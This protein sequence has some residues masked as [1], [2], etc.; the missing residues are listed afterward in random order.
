MTRNGI[1]M[2]LLGIDLGTSSVKV[3]VIDFDSGKLVTH[4]ALPKEE[5][6]IDTPRTGWAE[7]S[8]EKWWKY[9]VQAIQ[10][11][12]G[13]PSV[14]ALAIKGIGISYQMHGLVVVDK[15]HQPL[16]P[17]IIW[18]DSRAVEIGRNAFEVLG[19]EQCLEHFL[20]SPGNFTASKLKW[21][22]DNEPD[23]YKKIYKLMLPGDYLAMK[24]TGEIYTTISGLSE[25]ILWDFATK[26]PAKLL[27]DYYEIDEQL[28][29]TA[30]PSFGESGTLSKSAAQQLG[31]KAGIPIAY[32]AGDQPNNAFSL[33]AVHPG[34]IAATAGTS[35]V[36]YGVTDS[37]AYDRMS[38]VNSFAHVNYTEEHTS[39]GILLCVNGTGILNSWLKRNLSD[40][41]YEEMNQLALEVSPGADGLIILPFGNGAERVLMNHDVGAQVNNINFN[42]HT[43]AHLIRAAHEGIAYSFRYGMD[44]MNEL[45]LALNVMRAGYGNMFLSPI[46]GEALATV[47]NVDIELL[48]TDGSQGAARG[49]GVGIGAY[50]NF[51]QAMEG[52]EKVDVLHPDPQLSEI[53]NEGYEKWLYALEKSTSSVSI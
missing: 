49:A 29:P 12:V 13:H 5:M 44:I 38:R 46:F 3:S 27:L 10:T 52:L 25:G 42:I 30:L 36:V 8:P 28:L 48:N 53:Y 50:E 4:V 7:Q 21:V 16:R 45:G 9:T 26:T 18:C 11:V 35:G 41:S 32:K 22:K 15:D 14:D 37:I 17:S 34:E 33:G 19:N 24:M 40:M 6:G 43:D 1:H 23:T 31:L 39:L 20:N 51:D 2:Q 47:A